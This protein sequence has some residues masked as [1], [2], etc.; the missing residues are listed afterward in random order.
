[1]KCFNGLCDHLERIDY[2]GGLCYQPLFGKSSTKGRLCIHQTSRRATKLTRL[3][4]S[5]STIS[6]RGKNYLRMMLFRFAVFFT[7]RSWT[8]IFIL[9]PGETD[10]IQVRFDLVGYVLG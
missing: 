10:L 3:L 8:V 2:I 1:M 4:V 6:K 9:F 5:N 7:S